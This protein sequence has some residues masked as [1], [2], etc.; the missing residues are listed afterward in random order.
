MVIEN[1]GKFLLVQQEKAGIHGLWNLPAGKVEAND[2]VEQ[3]AVREAR[4]ETG[5][6]VKILGAL[7]VFH[8]K[9]E[10]TVKCAFSAK[11]IGGELKLPKTEIMNAQW[12]TLGQLESMTRRLRNRHWVLGAIRAAK[13]ARAGPSKRR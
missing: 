7:G 9:G 3:A 1:H 12:F 13:G 6:D 4:E 11:I 10:R 2:T 5:F 8:R